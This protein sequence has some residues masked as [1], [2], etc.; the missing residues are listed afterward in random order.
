MAGPY[1]GYLAS[2]GFRR[3][4]VDP[5][6]GFVGIHGKSLSTG[7]FQNMIHNQRRGIALATPEQIHAGMH[8]YDEGHHI[9]EEIGRGDV[10]K[11]AGIIAALSPKNEWNR[12]VENAREFIKTGTATGRT[13]DQLE[14]ATRI[15]EGESPEDILPMKLKTGH[16]FRLLRDPNDPTAVAVDTH[17]HDVSTGWKKPWA[18]PRGLKAPGRYN[19]FVNATIRTAE[20]EGMLPNQAQAIDWIVWK[21]LPHPRGGSGAAPRRR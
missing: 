18:D 15:Y 17:H 11:G 13:Q 12:N 2:R 4:A 1:P 21:D 3:V 5:T 7:Q 16:F 10:A 20:R 8:W 9:S 14:A 6:T 19:T